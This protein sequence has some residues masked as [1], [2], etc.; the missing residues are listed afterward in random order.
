MKVPQKVDNNGWDVEKK[1]E[2][3]SWAGEVNY[4][5]SEISNNVP[6]YQPQSAIYV[7]EGSHKNKNNPEG[8]DNPY[9]IPEISSQKDFHK[10]VNHENQ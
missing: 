9:G 2:R 8:R 5:G 4:R 1:P 10:K 6:T 3:K 7:A